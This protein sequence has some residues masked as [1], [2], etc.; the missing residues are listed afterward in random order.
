MTDPRTRIEQGITVRHEKHCRTHAG[1][2]CNCSPSYQARAWSN[3]AKREVKRSFKAKA[4]ARAWRARAIAGHADKIAGAVKSPVMDVLAEKVLAD[5]SAGRL[6]NK[7]G[8]PYKASAIRSYRS[9]Y[10]QHIKP[11]IGGRRVSVVARRDVQAIV[12]HMAAQGLK[13]STIRNAL[14]PLRLIYRVAI[15]DELGVTGSPLIGLEL[16]AVRGKRDRIATVDE[17]ATL[18]DT[19]APKDQAIW[20]TAFYA[21]LRRGELMAL[22]VEHVDLDAGVIRV[23]QAMDR[24]TGKVQTP[25]SRAGI[26]TVPI[27]KPLRRYLVAHMIAE[28]RRSGFIFGRTAT[29]PF[30]PESVND[31]TRVWWKRAKVEPIL[32]HECRHVWAS[33]MIAAGVNAKTL[34]ELGGWA[35]IAIVFDRYGHLMPGARDEAA[36]LLDDYIAREGTGSM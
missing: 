21:G 10:D 1:A 19:A 12:G 14:L 7:S 6:L 25:K 9:S 8:D 28:G 26:R 18:I 13:P 20:A 2:R 22:E 23:L 29:Q 3:A 35:S 27:I 31:R 32:M 33:M 16:P 11:A 5:A 15:R 4:D 34:Q 24:A 30:A 36:G 17:V